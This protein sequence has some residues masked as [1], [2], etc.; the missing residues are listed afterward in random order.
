MQALAR[1]F[2]R[3]S[4]GRGGRLDR[5]RGRRRAG[6][7]EEGGDEGA[8]GHHGLSNLV[9]GLQLARRL[10][11]QSSIL[12]SSTVSGSAPVIS[13]WAW[14][15]LRSKRSPSAL[16]GLGPQLEDLELADLVGERLAGN[17]D[18]A[19]DL[20]DHLGLAHA[21][22]VEHVAD[23]LLAGPTLGVDAGIDDQAH[24]PQHLVVEAAEALIGIG[25]HAELVP[26][27]LGV[28]RPALDE[29]GVAAE[30]HE[31]GQVGILV[32]EADLEMMARRALVEIERL[33]AVGPPRRQVVGIVI[34]DAG[35]RAV[36][37]AVL[38]GAAGLVALAEGLDLADLEP[39]A[40]QGR[41]I[42]ADPRVDL[43]AD[44]II[45]LAH[46][47]AA[48]RL[49]LAVGAQMLEEL[50]ERAVEA[51]PGLDRLHLAADPGDLAEA[52]IVDIVGGEREGRV[53]LDQPPVED[54]AAAHVDEADAVAGARQI[55][56]LQEVAQPA[57]GGEDAVADR[58][59]DGPAAAAPA[60]LPA[61]RQGSSGPGA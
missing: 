19:L 61:P 7:N 21:A 34:E 42:F 15:S 23:R 6:R 26:Q 43:A 41:E 4:R 46:P 35:P 16:L 3:G 58:P 32:G 33:H 60:P 48:L 29:G 57:V 27:G 54:V 18:V 14:K 45:A 59:R 22:I 5:Q 38:I 12:R 53:L 17:G 37:R 25:L 39:G 1:A 52:E 31:G 36:R 10:A 50:G 28:E 47:V 9:V 24:R 30:A 13:T 8:S 55:F 49:E 20:G 44:R 2:L 40:R 56:V 51:D 11:I